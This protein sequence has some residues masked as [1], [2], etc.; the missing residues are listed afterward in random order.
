[1]SLWNRN[2]ILACIANFSMF[3]AFYL[4]L[5]I[6]AIY[7]EVD[8]GAD[9]SMVGIVISSYV[10]SALLVRPFSGYLVDT[11]PR[12]RLLMFALATFAVCFA[13]Y[14]IATSVVFLLFVRILHGAAMGIT[15]V[16]MNTLALDIMPSQ[17]RGTGIG[18]FGVMSN[19]AMATGPMVAMMIYEASGSFQTNF[20]LSLIMAAFSLL[21]TSFIKADQ[22]VLP[23]QEKP[24]PLSLDRFIL[25]KGLRAA[26]SMLLISFSYGMLSTYIALY[27]KDVVGLASGAG[28]FFVFFAGG[29]MISRLIAGKFVNRG[30]FKQVIMFGMSLLIVTYAIFLTFHNE[31]VFYASAFCLGAGYGI[32]APAFQFMFIN[33]APHN[34]RGT[35]NATYFAS[36][37]A[38]IGLG[39]LCGGI[40]SDHVSM[41][42]AFTFG[43]VLLVI[44]TVQYYFSAAPYFDRMRNRV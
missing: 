12:K 44:G 7:L 10:I 1:M 17:K 13:G 32:L 29:I 2:F 14:I 39:V 34:K 22:T 3:F 19:M 26:L 42:A 15:T 36:W 25:L 33:L 24:E 21:I 35:A 18:Y 9:K 8:L 37:D 11:L 31:V 23:T 38:G 28:Q 27:G 6:L 43:G 30:L 5:P 20:R 41:I 16:S 40:I 4:I